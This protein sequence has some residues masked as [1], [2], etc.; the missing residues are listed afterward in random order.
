MLR[1]GHCVSEVLVGLQGGRNL[2][3]FCPNYFS[4]FDRVIWK[5]QTQLVFSDEAR[6]VLAPVLL[7]L[8]DPGIWTLLSLLEPS[9]IIKQAQ[10]FLLSLY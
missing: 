5:M 2:V 6:V 7:L 4:C 1:L 10:V 3:H 8:P 9:P